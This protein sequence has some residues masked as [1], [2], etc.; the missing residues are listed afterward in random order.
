[1]YLERSTSG[2]GRATFTEITV[3]SF[4]QQRAVHS[5][6]TRDGGYVA[7]H[8]PFSSQGRFP[9]DGVAFRMLVIDGG[10]QGNLTVA[11]SRFPVPL[12]TF[13]P[14][15]RGAFPVRDYTELGVPAERTRSI[16]A[17][18]EHYEALAFVG[19]RA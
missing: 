8:P 13:T 16:D 2:P 9:R 3:A 19:P 18:G 4:A 11:D 15:R 17:D 7:V 5:G 10:P 6:R 1:M 12:S 14:P